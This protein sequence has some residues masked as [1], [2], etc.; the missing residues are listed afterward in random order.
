MNSKKVYINC[1]FFCT[2]TTAL[3]LRII[4]YFVYNVECIHFISNEKKSYII[5]NN[6]KT[7]K[8]SE[9]A[10]VKVEWGASFAI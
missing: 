4:T 5:N 10:R 7:Q 2:Y 6:R 1:Q 9:T 8:N 3:A